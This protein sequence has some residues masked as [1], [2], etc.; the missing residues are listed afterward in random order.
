MKALHHLREAVRC[1]EL[2]EPCFVWVPVEAMLCISSSSVADRAVAASCRSARESAGVQCA[3]EGR[4]GA[5]KAEC[6]C[7]TLLDSVLM[8]R[9]PDVWLT[10]VS[11]GAE[12]YEPRAKG[13]FVWSYGS[14]H[15]DTDSSAS[16]ERAGSSLLPAVYWEKSDIHK[17]G[18]GKA[19]YNENACKDFIIP[20]FTEWL[21]YL[22]CDSYLT[23]EFW[24]GRQ[25]E[26][27]QQYLFSS[28]SSRLRYIAISS[29]SF[30]LV[31]RRISCSRSCFSMPLLTSCRSFSKHSISASKF[32][33]CMWYCC[34]VARSERS[35]PFSCWI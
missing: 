22:Q 30:I 2:S 18:T 12:W 24:R 8:C 28:C 4:Q 6:H 10:L 34:S 35:K 26:F 25:R 14:S 31:F 16:S 19:E 23:G 29:S 27:S 7:Q 1:W 11:G 17:C 13:S 32:C 15:T 3:G 5:A 33:S 9:A 21:L 20:H